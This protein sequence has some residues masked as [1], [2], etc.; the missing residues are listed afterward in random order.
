MQG[1]QQQQPQGAGPI[2]MP[3]DFYSGTTPPKQ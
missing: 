2:G 3:R 1:A